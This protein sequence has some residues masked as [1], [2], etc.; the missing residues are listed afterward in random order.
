MSDKVRASGAPFKM[1]REYR[2]KGRSWVKLWVA[3]WLDGTTRYEMTGA[4][5]A[6]WIDLL[7]MAGRSRVPGV[8]CA[9]W[10]NGQLFG[11]PL[12]R[13][14]GILNDASVD[15][16]ETLRLFERGKKIELICT[17][18]EDPALY[19][20][21][22]LSWDKYQSEYMRQRK[23]RKG[24]DKVTTGNTERCAIEVEVEGDG[25]VEVTSSSDDDPLLLLP[26]L[27]TKYPKF[28][29]TK[30]DV[31]WACGIIR[32]RATKPPGSLAYWR[33]ALFLFMENA[34]AEIAAHRRETSDKLEAAAGRN[35]YG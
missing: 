24:A 6:F 29:L 34:D 3:E 18:L 31:S 14:E 9:G 25:E 21:R 13:Y 35:T 32:K 10:D 5:R 26:E 11:Y 27:Q 7:T 4:Q 23:T 30:A 15:V 12:K 28:K 22:I 20:V 1:G 33:K 16:L 8:V 2:S 19:A 17:R